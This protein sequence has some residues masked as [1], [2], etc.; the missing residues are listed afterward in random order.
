MFGWITES[1]TGAGHGGR[2]SE[3]RQRAPAAAQA[4]TTSLSATLAA[5]W[6]RSPMSLRPRSSSTRSWKWVRRG[7]PSAQRR[8]DARHR[9]DRDRISWPWWFR[10]AARNHRGQGRRSRS[11]LGAGGSGGAAR[12]GSLDCRAGFS[13]SA[14]RLSVPQTSGWWQLPQL[15]LPPQPSDGSP[16]DLAALLPAQARSSMCEIHCK[17]DRRA[18]DLHARGPYATDRGRAGRPRPGRHALKP[19]RRAPNR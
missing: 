6:P 11:V 3:P 13:H 12:R 5:S 18:R 9:P 7:E 17:T 8:L 2:A 16:H 15:S 14:Q 1:R 10:P 4:V 19:D